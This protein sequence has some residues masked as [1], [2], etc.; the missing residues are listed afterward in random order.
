TGK[1]DD[2]TKSWK[3]GALTNLS[4]LRGLKLRE[5]LCYNNW[6]LRDFSP[7]QGMPLTNLVAG[8]TGITDLRPLAG[9]PLKNLKLYWTEVSDLSPLRGLSL[10]EL[11]IQHTKVTDLR[12]VQGSSIES[13]WV[14]ETPLTDVAQI[15]SLP[16]LKSIDGISKEE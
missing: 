9:L 5:F 15:K 1:W 4:P 10:E 3:P 13:L 16:K 8:S 11:D 6:E 7:L 14:D 12:P 2:S